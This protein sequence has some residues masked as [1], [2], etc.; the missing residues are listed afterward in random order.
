LNLA[1]AY[2]NRLAILCQGR[3]M[4]VDEPTKVLTEGL[5][6]EVYGCPIAVG[7]HPVRGCPLVMTLPSGT[8]RTSRTTGPRAHEPGSATAR[9][10]I[11]PG[12][13]DA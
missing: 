9:T 6:S 10:P 7:T 1:A 5:L 3:L 11:A 13:D 8:G 2:A 4:A 12:G